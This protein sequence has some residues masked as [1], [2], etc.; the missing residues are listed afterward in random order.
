MPPETIGDPRA[1]QTAGGLADTYTGGIDVKDITERFREKY[2]VGTANCWLWQGARNRDGYG[3]FWSGEYRF[4]DS[5]CG[6]IMVLAHRWSYEHHVGP[7]GDGLCVLHR[8]DTPGCVNP[9]HLF[10]GTQADNVRDCAEKGRRNQTRPP[11]PRKPCS[12][13]GCESTAVSR[14]WCER[15]YTRWYKHGTVDAP[16]RGKLTP[17]QRDEI[18]QRYTGAF[19]EQTALAREYGVTQSRISAIV[20]GRP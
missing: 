4:G 15:H 14:G 8:C 5:S 7:I 2:E 13:D 9:D 6:P 3:S 20:G 11:R 19:G 1:A 12:V 18:R 16:G 10:L 17:E